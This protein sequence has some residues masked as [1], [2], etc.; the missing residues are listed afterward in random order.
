MK[1][2]NGGYSEVSGTE[3]GKDAGRCQGERRRGPALLGEKWNP[4][5]S[6]QKKKA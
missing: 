2:G 1:A 6:E 4:S 3:I 5:K